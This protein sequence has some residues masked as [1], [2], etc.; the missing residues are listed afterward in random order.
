M[1]PVGAAHGKSVDDDDARELC[2]VRAYM[3]CCCWILA[4]AAAA[5]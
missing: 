5:R 2:A 1:W 4:A 3:L